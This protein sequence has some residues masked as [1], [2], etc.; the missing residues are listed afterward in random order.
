MSRFS[1]RVWDNELNQWRDSCF[2]SDDGF[3]YK[4]ENTGARILLSGARYTVEQ[5]TGLL[6]ISGKEI[7]EGDILQIKYKHNEPFISPVMWSDQLAGYV[8]TPPK[9]KHECMIWPY[10]DKRE[11]EY[12]SV[13]EILG[14]IHENPEL[15][16][17]AK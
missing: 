6:D 10:F 4:I 3:L 11:P 8:V 15:V 7:F 12:I 9:E 2:V 13:I 14:N 17:G 1:F 16:G 5:S